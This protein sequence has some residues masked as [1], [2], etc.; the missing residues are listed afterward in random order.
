MHPSFFAMLK[1]LDLN[2]SAGSLKGL[3]EGLSLILGNAFLNVLGSALNKLLSFLQAKAGDLTNS[4]DNVE[5]LSAEFLQNYVKLGLLLSGGSSS[6]CYGYNTYG[7][8]SGYA[9]LLLNC[10]YK[11]SKLK[12]GKRLDL[13]QNVG[14]LFGCHFQFPPKLWI[15]ILVM[16]ALCALVRVMKPPDGLQRNY[17]SSAGAGAA[18]SAPSPSLS[19]IAW[20]AYAKP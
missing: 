10:L 15:V 1:L 3:L 5:L 7:S 20:M 11:V 6:A 9:E 18:S 19:I 8:S 16:F 14:N 17:A 12:N 13:F 4:L 2:N